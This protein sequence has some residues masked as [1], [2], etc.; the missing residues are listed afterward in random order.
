[1]TVAFSGHQSGRA[2]GVR[3]L[4]LQDPVAL[5]RPAYLVVVVV[6]P[7]QQ[8]L[9]ASR[10][11]AMRPLARHIRTRRSVTTAMYQRGEGISNRVVFVYVRNVRV[12]DA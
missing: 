8:K 7:G 1:M 6:V 4:R 2:R 3:R 11:A 5:E 12:G 9:S 10:R